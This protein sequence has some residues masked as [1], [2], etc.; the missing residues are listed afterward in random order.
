M[1]KN[2]SP[3]LPHDQEISVQTYVGDAVSDIDPFNYNHEYS[4]NF[5]YSEDI[6]ES[7]F[8]GDMR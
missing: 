7:A 3:Q 4:G 1:V 5:A 6:N 8:T 2:K